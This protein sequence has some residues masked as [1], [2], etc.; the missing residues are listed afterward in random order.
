M[1]NI[2]TEVAKK[3]DS[4]TESSIN[5]LIKEISDDIAKIN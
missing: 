2:F 3:N 5:H 4:T 1:P